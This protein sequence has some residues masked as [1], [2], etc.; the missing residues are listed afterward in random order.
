ME[1]LPI[2]RPEL[3]R[4]VASWLAQKENTKWLDFGDGK[5]VVSPE[6]LKIMTQLDTYFL[7]VWTTD[8]GKPIGV[9]GLDAVN[10]TFRT[11]RFWAVAGDRTHRERG[12]GSRAS[13]AMFTLAFRDLGLRAISSWIVDTDPPNPSLSIALRQNFKIIGRQ[14]QCHWVDGRVYDRLW[15]DLLACEH[16]EICL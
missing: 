7:R 14:R 12:Y 11:A 13:S 2:D 9:A 5:Q 6:W 10:R 3:V 16:K 4:L 8:E 1:L 15:L